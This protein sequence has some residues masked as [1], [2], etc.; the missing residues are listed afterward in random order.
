MLAMTS[1]EDTSPDSHRLL[2]LRHGEV[3]SHRGDVPVT[4]K[5]LVYAQSVGEEIASIS[6][7]VRV[8]HGETKRT[9][10]TAVALADGARSSGADV[11]GPAEAYAMRNP[12]LYVA[13]TRVSMV[14]SAEALAAQVPGMS[15][16]EAAKVPFFKAFFSAS[17]RIKCWLDC[18]APPGE[19]AADITTRIDH[20]AKSLM[21]GAGANDLT[22]GVT[23]S[24]ILRAVM[25]ATLGE[26]PGEPA[27]VSGI[28]AEIDA[29]RRIQWS[30]V[31]NPLQLA[32]LAARDVGS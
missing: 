7:S 17:D 2:L 3:T 12:D 20:F 10:Q 23:H 15:S 16:D 25:I 1:H 6:N 32:H 22:I 30:I 13:G 11:S 24:P 18:E 8:F 9:R 26:D 29:K 28:S 14:S 5:G 27:W 4:D 21:D 31:S 19:G